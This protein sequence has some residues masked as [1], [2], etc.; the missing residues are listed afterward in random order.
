MEAPRVL[1]LDK[2]RKK[3]A[4]VC[5]GFARYF[6]V[7]VVLMRVLWLGIAICSGGIG[8]L[9]YLA[10]WIVVPSDGGVEARE[11]GWCGLR[12][13]TAERTPGSGWIQPDWWCLAGR[14][15]CARIENEGFRFGTGGA[16]IHGGG[17]EKPC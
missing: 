9:V 10:A 5:A 16:I 17:L 14:I 11:V 1:M 8:F 3:I 4:G 13:R 12:R 7:D 2:R 15:S 6:D